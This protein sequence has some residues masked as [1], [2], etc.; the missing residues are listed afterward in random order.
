MCLPTRLQQQLWVLVVHKEETV[1]RS[2]TRG[3]SLVAS[4]LCKSEA[5]YWARW[6]PS[7]T[8]WGTS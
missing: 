1:E 3:L 8:Q 2:L 7:E 6:I 5:W 4:L